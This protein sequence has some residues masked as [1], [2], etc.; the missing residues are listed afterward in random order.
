MVSK[1]SLEETVTLNLY[2]Y[3]NDNS[4]PCGSNNLIQDHV[5]AEI[6]CSDCG[7]VLFEH[8]MNNSVRGQQLFFTNKEKYEKEHTGGQLTPLLPYMGL[9]TKIDDSVK[10]SGK[11]KQKFKRLKKWNNRR[12]WHQTN[13]TIAMNEIRRITS[14]LQLPKHITDSSAILY[15]KVLKKNFVRGRSIKSMVAASIYVTCKQ[16]GIPISL[17]K[18]ANLSAKSKKLIKKSYFTIL[19][20]FNIKLKKYSPNVYATLI[21]NRL[22]LSI[23]VENKAKKIIDF[24][25]NSQLLVGKNPKGIAAAAVFRSASN[26]KDKKSQSMISKAIKITEVTLR[27]RLHDLDKILE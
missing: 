15:R 10:L 12:N 6:I 25:K 20:E 24:C 19:K 9:M 23:E 22:K 18:I 16:M 4:C 17:D 26:L 11:N 27:N 2:D 1:S 13:I 14:Q 3:E 8:V 7:L 21:C 5:R